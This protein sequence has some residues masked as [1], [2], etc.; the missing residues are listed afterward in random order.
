MG[1]GRIGR[2]TARDRFVN[3]VI[4][5]AVASNFGPYLIGGVRTDQVVLYGTSLAVVVLAP[6]AWL[7]WRPTGLA[8][9]LTAVWFGYV[10]VGITSSLGAPTGRYL[11]GSALAGLDNLLL[12]LAALATVWLLVTPERRERALVTACLTTVW[13]TAANGFLSAVAMRVDL[14]RILRPF[15]ASSGQTGTVAELAAGNGRFS[16]I[17]NQPAEAG[18]MYGLAGLAAVYVYR[19][20]P[21]RMY[22]TLAPIFIGGVLCVSKVF[23]LAAAPLILWQVWRTARSRVVLVLSI[24]VAILGLGQSRLLQDWSGAAFLQRL[25]RPGQSGFIDLYTAGRIGGGSSLMMVTSEVQNRS[26]LFGFGARGLSVAYDNGWVAALVVAGAFG[27]IAYT[28]I[29]VILLLLPRTLLGAERRLAL[30]TALLAVMASVG[31]PALTANRSGSVLWLLVALLTIRQHRHKTVKK[32][33]APG[34][35]G[36]A[37]DLNLPKTVAS[38]APRISYVEETKEVR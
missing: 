28:A 31:V 2:V 26:P 7:R 35:P 30:G 17:F 22:L 3:L 32:L 27:A 29:L 33:M 13:L 10:L 9:R 5:V 34:T 20:R 23:L 25:L 8:I 4:V 15:W 16:G 12:P 1:D 37:S 19:D 36:L 18:L 24:S 14:S 38:C 6:W 21:S 11:P